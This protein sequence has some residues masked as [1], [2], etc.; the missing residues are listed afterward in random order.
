MGYR[1]D[2]VKGEPERGMVKGGVFI[3]GS[4]GWNL[5]EKSS[6]LDLVTDP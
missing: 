3:Q 5:P 4:S 1:E 6:S 2:G